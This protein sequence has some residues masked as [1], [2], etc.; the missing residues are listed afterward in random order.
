MKTEK[1]LT[2]RVDVTFEISLYEYG[3]ARDPSDGY[4]VYTYPKQETSLD[5]DDPKDFHWDYT[6]VSLEDVIE[7]LLEI[8]DGYFDFV[9]M[10][11]VEILASLDNKFLAHEISSINQYNGYFQQSCTWHY[12][13]MVK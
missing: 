2:D 11:K 10:T 13:P 9:G 6:I 3:I 8:E 12:A 5:S 4:V 7:A 1:Q